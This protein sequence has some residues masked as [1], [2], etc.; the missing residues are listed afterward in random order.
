MSEMPKRYW[1]SV[2]ERDSPEQVNGDPDFVTDAAQ[3]PEGGR[4]LVR[5]RRRVE[6]QPR[7]RRRRRCRTCAHPE[8]IVPGR[9]VLYATTCGGCEAGCGVLV[10]TRDGRPLKIEGNPDHPL[11]GGATCAVGQASILGLYDSLRL[12]YPTQ[13]RPAAARG[14][15]STRRSPT[16]LGATQTGGRRRPDPDADDHQPDHCGA[17]RRIPRRIHE[18]AARH[19][20]SDLG[21][22]DPRR[23]RADPRRPAAAALPLRSRR[24]HRQRRRRFPRHLDLAG[25]VHARLHQ[26]AASR[27]T[28]S[29]RSPTTCRSSRG[30]R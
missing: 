15:T 14:P 28:A 3:L 9:P 2:V 22:G 29:R 21:V 6:L 24:R 18:R 5:R 30:C 7:A 11:S 4:L 27:T 17:H 20:R 12:A 16:T 8:G 26:P 23:A 1:M 10:T 19:L 13:R 25:G